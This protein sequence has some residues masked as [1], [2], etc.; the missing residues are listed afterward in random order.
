MAR[1][2]LTISRIMARTRRPR[3]PTNT[4]NRKLEHTTLI[5]APT[6][7]K[8]SSMDALEVKL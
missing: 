3:P 6:R 1:M 8:E 5:R 2:A 7:N 4:R